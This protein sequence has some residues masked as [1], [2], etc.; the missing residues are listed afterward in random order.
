MPRRIYTLSD[1]RVVVE[2]QPFFDGTYNH[3]AEFLFRA[4]NEELQSAGITVTEEPDLP[5]VPL[6]KA[7]LLKL[8]DAR[9]EKSSFGGTTVNIAAEDD[10]PRMVYVST[11][12]S[13]KADIL[14]LTALAAK[15]HP[16]NWIQSDG[17]FPVTAAQL[18]IMAL[19]LATHTG[20][21]I[22]IWTQIRQA[23]DLGLVTTTEQIEAAPWPTANLS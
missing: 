6:T 22:A 7:E 13:G 8:L 9:W 2:G 18:D 16:I 11:D 3:S 4:S 5:P 10:D 1:G 17:A 21:A 19:A 20:T 12:A 23:I 14:G 15:G